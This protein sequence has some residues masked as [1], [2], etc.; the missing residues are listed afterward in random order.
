MNNS[1]S[2]GVKEPE[3]DNCAPIILNKKDRL[4]GF[5]IWNIN[6]GINVNGLELPLMICLPQLLSA[7]TNKVGTTHLKLSLDNNFRE[8]VDN[9]LKTE[10]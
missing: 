2:L 1:K 5:I 8:A 6:A 3:L 7:M 10:A 4:L 9:R